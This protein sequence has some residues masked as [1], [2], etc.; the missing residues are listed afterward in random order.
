MFEFAAIEIS[1]YISEKWKWLSTI[2][3]VGLQ[4]MMSSAICSMLADSAENI[5][6]TYLSSASLPPLVKYVKKLNPI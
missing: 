4:A 3:R 6:E 2:I 5:G 1:R